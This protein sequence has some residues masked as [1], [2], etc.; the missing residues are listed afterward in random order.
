MGQ[1]RGTG[2]DPQRFRE[3]LGQH[4][5]GVSI[6]TGIA[7]SGAP[8]GLA[9]GTFSSVSLDPPL[10]A[11]MPGRTSASWP[12]IAPT[13]RFCINVLGEHQEHVCRVF[14]SKAPDKFAELGW[15]PAGTGSPIIDGV[16][17]WIDCELDVVHEA[18]DHDIVVGRVLALEI[19]TP[20]R[21]LI[22]FQGGYGRFAPASSASAEGRR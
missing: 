9:V 3:V 13:G 10:V 19:E 15:R 16:V 7:E 11:F 4:P 22:F 1:S 12:K 21:P 20:A 6:V 14:A 17:A 5:T 2:H 18:G 8:V